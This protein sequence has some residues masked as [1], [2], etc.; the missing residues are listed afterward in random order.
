V[1]IQKGSKDTITVD[2]DGSWNEWS[3]YVLKELERLANDID[4]LEDELI[5]LKEKVVVLVVK[6]GALASA[7]SVIVSLVIPFIIRF[8][9]PK[10]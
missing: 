8:L 9:L 3:K 6:V 1:K 4:T 10:I 7:I 5:E 2:T